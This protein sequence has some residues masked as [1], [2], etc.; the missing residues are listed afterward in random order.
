MLIVVGLVLAQDP[1]QMGLVP[2]E[3]MVQEFT[4]ASADPAFGDRVHAR[5]PDVAQHNLD[6]GGGED[7]VER[8]ADS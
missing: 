1:P 8:G 4:S 5:R 7:R 6:A 2:A 3:G